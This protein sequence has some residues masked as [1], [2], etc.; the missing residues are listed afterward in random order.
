MNKDPVVVASVVCATQPVG[1][2]IPG[3]PDPSGDIDKHGEGVG[4]LIVNRVASTKT[5]SR[6]RTL[7]HKAGSIFEWPVFL[8]NLGLGPGWPQLGSGGPPEGPDI[9]DDFTTGLSQIITQHEGKLSSRV[10]FRGDIVGVLSEVASIGIGKLWDYLVHCWRT[11]NVRCDD[12]MGV[13]TLFDDDPGGHSSPW[14]PEPSSCLCSVLIKNCSVD[15]V[16]SYLLRNVH[17]V[18]LYIMGVTAVAGVMISMATM[19]HLGG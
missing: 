10:L 14:W 12:M 5:D 7:H 17:L 18:R 9:V 11:R 16:V 19:I 13:M 15:V 8:G 6:S 4:E 3:L 2:H 1:A